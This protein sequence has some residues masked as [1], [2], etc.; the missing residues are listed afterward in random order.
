MLADVG[1][2][3]PVALAKQ[4]H[5]GFL[6]IARALFRRH[7][8]GRRAVGNDRAIEQVQGRGDHAG[9]EHVGNADGRRLVR[10]RIERRVAANRD[11]D[12]GHLLRRGAVFMHV[13]LRD[14]R[15]QRRHERPVGRLELR[16][17]PAGVCH[18]LH[19]RTA[20]LVREQVLPRDA[21]HGL[22]L[23][24]SDRHR[25]VMN[26]RGA[27]S[28]RHVERCEVTRPDAERLRHHAARH[29]PVG[30]PNRRRQKPVDVGEREPRVRERRVRRGTLQLERPHSRHAAERAF[31]YARDDGA[32]QGARTHRRTSRAISMRWISEEPSPTR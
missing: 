15:I 28:A 4:A 8:V 23:S 2:R 30:D 3:E 24:R 26:H 13:A 27:G 32:L 1:M 10:E 22:G 25:R 5:R 14:E 12:L 18:E 9:G 11:R 31:A 16:M 6:Q 17:R 29:R 20:R 7:H 21:E 19:G